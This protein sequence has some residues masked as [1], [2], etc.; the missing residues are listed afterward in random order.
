MMQEQLEQ[1]SIAR[2]PTQGEQVRDSLFRGLA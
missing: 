2:P 1:A